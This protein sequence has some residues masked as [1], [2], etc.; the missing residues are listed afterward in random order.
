MR[1]TVERVKH[2]YEEDVRFLGKPYHTSLQLASNTKF[3]TS[4]AVKGLG[5]QAKS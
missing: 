2:N 5:L 1:Y 4:N 3:Q